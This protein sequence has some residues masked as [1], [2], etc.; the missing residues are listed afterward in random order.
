MPYKYG[1][2]LKTIWLTAFYAPFVP[3][4]VPLSMIGL[5]INYWIEKHLFRYAYSVPNTLSSM[6]NE[7]GM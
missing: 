4:V 5:G 7:N 6:I 1:Y 2:I 3:V